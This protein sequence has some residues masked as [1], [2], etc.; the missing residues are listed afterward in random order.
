M[1]IDLMKTKRHIKIES[2]PLHKH[3][4][5]NGEKYK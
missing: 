2:D 3:L 5:N 4:K 1:E